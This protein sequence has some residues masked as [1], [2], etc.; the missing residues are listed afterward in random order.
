MKKIDSSFHCVMCMHTN[1][2]SYER[3]L[4][5]MC[6]SVLYKMLEA[7][8]AELFTGSCFKRNLKRY[9]LSSYEFA[10]V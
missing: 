8:I 6:S 1:L 4:D 5:H 3:S 2:S 10:D 7:F 9:L